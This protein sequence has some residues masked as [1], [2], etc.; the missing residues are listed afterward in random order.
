M[1][2]LLLVIYLFGETEMMEKYLKLCLILPNSLEPPVGECRL[3]YRLG[4]PC[5]TRLFLRE[6]KGWHIM[7]KEG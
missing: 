3:S 5:S 4:A 1:H 2:L 6:Q 7:G